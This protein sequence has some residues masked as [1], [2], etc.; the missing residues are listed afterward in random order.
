MKFKSILLGFIILVLLAGCAKPPIAE[1]DSAKEAVF[2]AENDE[3]AVLYGGG[4]LSRARDS[5]RRMQVEADSK[6]YDAAKTHAA[7]A[8][9]AAERAIADGKSGIARSKSEAESLIG[10]L[11]PAIEET[12]R[13]I[14]GARYSQL[15]LDYGQM[16]REVKKAYETT[17][18]AEIDLAMGRYQDATDKGMSVRATLSA[19]NQQIADIIPRKKS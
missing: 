16:N 11:R 12:E 4:S 14:N 10:G 13:N 7:E 17:D 1:M 6:R 18:Q 9:A 2:R 15:K 5:L 3:A 19:I 8:I